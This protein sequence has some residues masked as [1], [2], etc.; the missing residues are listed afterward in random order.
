[1]KKIIFIIPIIALL[2]SSCKDEDTPNYGYAYYEST[3]IMVGEQVGGDLVL[4][5]ITDQSS[6]DVLPNE[7]SEWVSGTMKDGKVVLNLEPNTGDVSRE[8]TGVIYLGY[9]KLSFRVFQRSSGINHIEIPNPTESES[10][11]WTASCSDEQANDGGGV[12]MIFND[13]QT[14]FWHSQYSPMVNLPHWVMVDLKEEKQINQVRLGWRK[15]N[16]NYYVNTKKTI[17]Q[18]SN[19][20]TNWTDVGTILREMTE[21]TLSSS[22]YTPYSDCTFNAVSA[23][24]V[25]MYI[26]ES[27]AANGTCNIAYFKVFMP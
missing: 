26:T 6:C 18:V 4:P 9:N 20:G 25:R 13:D 8:G 5:I 19:D 21:G 2:L 10:L 11:S 12:N 17:I 1:M 3:G 24:Y 14:K 16:Q 23:R 7:G 15:Y 22:K 27:N